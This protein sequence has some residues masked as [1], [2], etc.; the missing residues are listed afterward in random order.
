MAVWLCIIILTFLIMVCNYCVSKKKNDSKYNESIET[1]GSILNNIVF[2]GELA[3]ASGKIYYSNANDNWSLY[4][5]N[6]KASCI[7]NKTGL[8]CTFYPTDGKKGKKNEKDKNYGVF[9]V[10]DYALWK[11]VR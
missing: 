4:C 3:E 1:K 8:S 2:G 6:L 10:L 5:K 11:G 7:I 9:R